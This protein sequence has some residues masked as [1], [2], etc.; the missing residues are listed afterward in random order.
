MSR[1][2]R[3][4]ARHAGPTDPRRGSTKTL[5]CELPLPVRAEALS[6]I[7]RCYEEFGQLFSGLEGRAVRRASGTFSVP[8]PTGAQ[9]K[10]RG[11]E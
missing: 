4:H 5:D 8:A 7:D 10:A 11:G 3:L 2:E 6:M 1:A 9:S